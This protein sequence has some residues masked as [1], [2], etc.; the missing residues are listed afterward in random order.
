MTE[1]LDI[2]L[3]QCQ[4]AS[5]L[6]CLMLYTP[7]ASPVTLNAGDNPLNSVTTV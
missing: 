6:D 3:I 5:T 7:Y 4:E 1:Q 2:L